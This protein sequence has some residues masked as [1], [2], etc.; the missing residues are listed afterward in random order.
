M[1]LLVQH[2][3][4]KRLKL[5]PQPN[6]RPQLP[7]SGITIPTLTTFP[8]ISWFLGWKWKQRRANLGLFWIQLYAPPPAGGFSKLIFVAENRRPSCL[9]SCSYWRP[10]QKL[11][12]IAFC[13]NF[14]VEFFGVRTTDIIS[15][16][17][18]NKTASLNKM[19]IN[20]YIRRWMVGNT[21]PNTIVTLCQKNARHV[22]MFFSDKYRK[23]ASGAVQYC[24]P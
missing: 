15:K 4:T 12:K 2:F 13:C 21:R 16:L 7:N 14:V 6:I 10:L 24:R 5:D 11:S 22:C 23:R 17:K 9:S 1:F 20:F 18:I 8:P 19:L 3:H